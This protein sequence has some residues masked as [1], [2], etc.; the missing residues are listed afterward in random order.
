MYDNC[1]AILIAQPMVLAI[2]THDRMLKEIART[3]EITLDH[4]LKDEWKDCWTNQKYFR[5]VRIK[6]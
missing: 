5:V 1:F 4:F 3:L 6:D 2:N